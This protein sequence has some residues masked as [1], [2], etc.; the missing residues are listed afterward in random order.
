LRGA[1]RGRGRLGVRQKAPGPQVHV[2]AHRARGREPDPV[3]EQKK[4]IDNSVDQFKFNDEVFQ[5]SWA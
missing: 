3:C 5:F 1:A 2:L 4:I